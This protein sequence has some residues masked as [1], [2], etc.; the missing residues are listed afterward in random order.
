MPRMDGIEVGR[1]L[2]SD[3]RTACFAVAMH[4]SML[5][6]DIR[7]SFTDYEVFLAQRAGFAL[8]ANEHAN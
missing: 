2:R 4:T 1:R 8:C 7:C 3:P 6:E 5:E